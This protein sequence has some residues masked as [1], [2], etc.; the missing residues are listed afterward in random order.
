M[1]ALAT[2]APT[3]F[4]L[5]LTGGPCGGK[6]TL[7]EQLKTNMARRGFDVL[8]APEVPTIMIRGGAVYPGHDG[9]EKLLAFETAIIRL[10]MQLEDAFSMVAV[11]TGKPSIIVM[12]RGLL[13]IPAYLPSAQWHE[14]LKANGTTEA[15]LSARYDMVLHLV[16]A[17]DGAEAYYTTVNNAARTETAEQ[18][19][20]LDAS[21]R[22]NW[23]RAHSNVVVVDNSGSD[24]AEKVRRCVDAV[25]RFVEI[26]SA[27]GIV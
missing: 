24:F 17:A 7:L 13:D 9:G 18:A 8:C 6:S 16:T 12:D 15:A 20:A 25:V 27:R 11:S 10:Q 21:I 3:I 26:K 4:R 19:R 23:T 14:V 22:E 2:T 1:A 5:C